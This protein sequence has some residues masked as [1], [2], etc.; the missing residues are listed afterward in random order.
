MFI[1]SSSNDGITVSFSANSIPLSFR[2]SATFVF[3]EITVISYP[4]ANVIVTLFKFAFPAITDTPRINTVI[5]L[6]ITIFFIEIDA[7]SSSFFIKII[8]PP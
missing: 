3:D 1:I 4:F 2:I 8:I 5:K 6:I 7:F